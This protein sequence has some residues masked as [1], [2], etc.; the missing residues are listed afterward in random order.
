MVNLNLST[1]VLLPALL[2]AGATTTMVFSANNGMFAKI[3]D[4]VDDPTITTMPGTDGAVPLTREWTGVAAVD[5][6]FTVLLIFFWQLLD[7]RHPAGTLQAAHFFGQMGAY[8]TLMQLEAKRE[9][10]KRRIIA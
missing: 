3:T 6:Q 9:G 7:G 10:N 4:M 1:T 5:R 2:A 8:W